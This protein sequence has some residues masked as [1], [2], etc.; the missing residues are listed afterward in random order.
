MSLKGTIPFKVDG[1]DYTLLLDFNA[2]CD[3]EDELPGLMDG[4]AEIKSPKAIRRVFHAG[5]SEYHAGLDERDAGKLIHSLG[6][7]RAAELVKDAF[8]ASFGQAKGGEVSS[9]PRK[10]G[11]GSAR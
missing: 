8:D 4:T 10:P 5:L 9:R 6:L 3:L 1:D 7:E 11:A 2:L